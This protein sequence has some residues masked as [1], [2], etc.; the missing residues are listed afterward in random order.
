MYDIQK[1]WGEKGLNCKNNI[2]FCNTTDK[3]NRTLEEIGYF[4]MS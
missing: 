2:L 1:N 4:K 3:F